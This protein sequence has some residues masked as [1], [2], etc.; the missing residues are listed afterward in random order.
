MPLATAR[1]GS[2]K[3]RWVSRFDRF[4][5][6]H[7]HVIGAAALAG[8]F[9]AAY[10]SA[11][12]CTRTIDANQCLYVLYVPGCLEARPRTHETESVG[13]KPCIAISTKCSRPRF[14]RGGGSHLV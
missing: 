8:N 3:S 11:E 12:L 14:G 5:H 4:R 2:S 13:N 10:I 9:S 1:S 7:W 6:A